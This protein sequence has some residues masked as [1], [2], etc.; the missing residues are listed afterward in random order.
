VERARPRLE[1]VRGLRE[2]ELVEEDLRQLPVP[3]LAGVEHDLVEAA[4]AERDRE[5]RRFDELRPVPDNGEDL[6]RRREGYGR[7]PPPPVGLRFPPREP[8]QR[9]WASS[10]SL[11][12]ARPRI[13][14]PRR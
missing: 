12:R 5:R 7:P 3:V 1:P 2:P 14:S 6:H 11:V 13:P 4:L 10:Q 9:W 8:I